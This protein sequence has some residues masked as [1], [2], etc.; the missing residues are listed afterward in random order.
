M[1]FLSYTAAALRAQ[2]RLHTEYCMPSLPAW[3]N[4]PAP[5]SAASS[6]SASSDSTSATTTAT[7]AVHSSSLAADAPA[8]GDGMEVVPISTNDAIAANGATAAADAAAVISVQADAAVTAAVALA[9][10]DLW[11][12][13][14]ALTHGIAQWP[15]IWY[16]DCNSAVKTVVY[17]CLGISSQPAMHSLHVVVFHFYLCVHPSM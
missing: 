6:V 14:A 5:L 3:W 13:R 16:C 11:I 12:A 4:A 17:I 15:T 10:V 1:Y 7:T 9:P 2:R 8:L